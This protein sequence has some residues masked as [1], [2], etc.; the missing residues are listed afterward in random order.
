MIWP[1][2]AVARVVH[3]DLMAQ[4]ITNFYE[5]TFQRQPPETQ[6]YHTPA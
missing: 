2:V 5:N 1:E 4:V 6:V 3:R